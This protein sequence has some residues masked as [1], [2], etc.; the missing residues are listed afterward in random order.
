MN[1]T[2]ATAVPEVVHTTAPAT[3]PTSELPASTEQRMTNGE[4]DTETR[5]Q[6]GNEEK[7]QPA[8]APAQDTEMGGTT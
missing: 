3:A 6:Q 2:E 4:P 1:G 7:E 8:E 5:A